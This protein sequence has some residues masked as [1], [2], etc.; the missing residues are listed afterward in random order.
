[1]AKKRRARVVYHLEKLLEK[2]AKE[3]GLENSRFGYSQQRLCEETGL[4]QT[5]IRRMIVG[6]SALISVETVGT[7]MDFFGCDFPE[8]F[9]IV[10]EDEEEE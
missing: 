2:K 5:T 10:I 9:T 8:V 6:G 1:M 4:S 7:L 3:L